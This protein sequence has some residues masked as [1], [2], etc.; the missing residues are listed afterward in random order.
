M[1]SFDLDLSVFNDA[2]FSQSEFWFTQPSPPAT[3]NFSTFFWETTPDTPTTE[4]NVFPFLSTTSSVSGIHPES[5]TIPANDMARNYSSRYGNVIGE[6]AG[7]EGNMHFSIA[8]SAT[9][10]VRLMSLLSS[11]NSH[12]EATQPVLPVPLATTFPANW[13]K[14]PQR[15]YKY[16]SKQL[17]FDR[18][19]TIHFSSKDH[20]GI[21]LRE[22][23]SKDFTSLNGR[24]DPM[25]RGTSG[26]ISCRLLVR[27]HAPPPR[28]TELT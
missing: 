9:P 27:L 7:P 18:S 24:D 14:I 10:P 23:L 17:D 5:T 6:D 11:V 15:D 22:A 12:S 25:L 21:N 16:G 13:I 2:I 28:A 1:D 19:E 20:P 26:V 8:F 3:E 4:Q